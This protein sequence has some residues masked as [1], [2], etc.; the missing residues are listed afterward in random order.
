MHWIFVALKFH[1]WPVVISLGAHTMFCVVFGDR[2]FNNVCY[3]YR[4]FR[5]LYETAC[6]ISS[7]AICLLQ[8]IK[9]CHCFLKTLNNRIRLMYIP[10]LPRSTRVHHKLPSLD[11]A[12]QQFILCLWLRVLLIRCISGW[13]S[14]NA[15]DRARPTTNDRSKPCTRRIHP[16]VSCSTVVDVIMS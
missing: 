9:Y 16:L 13:N 3:F 8:H 15:P 5:H 2:I 4:Q 7:S 14:S 6:Q 11:L 12:R 1:Y 10:S